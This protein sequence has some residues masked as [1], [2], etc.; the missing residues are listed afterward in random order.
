MGEA[1]E[2]VQRSPC[3]LLGCSSRRLRNQDPLPRVATLGRRQLALATTP[4]GP[5]IH[6]LTS[7]RHGQV[8]AKQLRKPADVVKACGLVRAVEDSV[9]RLLAKQLRLYN[10]GLRKTEQ[11]L[12]FGSRL[13][14]SFSSRAWRS[15]TVS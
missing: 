15:A 5:P 9:A 2:V 12:R 7:C 14:P 3:A 1:S 13:L 4:R 6:E 11:A 8:V 10:A